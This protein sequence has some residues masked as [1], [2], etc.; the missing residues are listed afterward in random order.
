MSEPDGVDVAFRERIESVFGDDGRAWLR[1]LP[2]LLETFAKQWQLTLGEPFM[3]LNYNYVVAAKRADGSDAVLKMG[4]P[5]DDLRFELEALRHYAGGASIEL[6]EADAAGGA[7]L[8]ERASPGAPI[9]SL[10]DDQLATRIA[11]RLM[12]KLWSAP[13]AGHALPSVADWGEAFAQLRERHGGRSGP[14]PAELFAYA[15]GLYFELDESRK[16]EVVLHGDLHHWN[17]V[18]AEREP[19]LAIDPHGLVGDPGFEVGSWM[20]NPV[21]DRGYPDEG[22]FLMRQ[23]DVRGVLK[24][25]LEIFSEELGIDRNRLRDWSI[26]FAVLSAC[27]SDESGDTRG[28]DQAVFVAEALRTM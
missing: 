28:R 9:L 11:A 6:L 7:M 22:R 1:A 24:R 27:W 3:P 15:E 8:L 13:A 20:R 21:G 16:H 19:W 23:R 17:I 14:I 18:S 2:E 5:R 26:A 12:R 10:D 25:R 4:V